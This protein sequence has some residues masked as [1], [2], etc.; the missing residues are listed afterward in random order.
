MQASTITNGLWAAGVFNHQHDAFI[1]A[2]TARAQAVAAHMPLQCACTILW[3]LGRLRYRDDAATDALAGAV[4]RAVRK[5]QPQLAP[6]WEDGRTAP[7]R[8]APPAPQPL[9]ELRP[10]TSLQPPAVDANSDALVLSPSPQLQ[11]AP[12]PVVPPLARPAR[13]PAQAAATPLPRGAPPVAAVGRSLSKALHA[14]ASLGC[15]DSAAAQRM[16]RAVLAFSNAHL[17]SLTAQSVVNVTWAATVA[18]LH[19]ERAAVS[20]LLLS[21]LLRGDELNA[22]EL[23]Q[24]AQVDFAL[25]LEAPWYAGNE[26]LVEGSHSELLTALYWLGATRCALGARV[27]G[28]ARNLL[29]PSWRASAWRCKEPSCLCCAARC[30]PGH[31]QLCRRQHMERVPT[32]RSPQHILSETASDSTSDAGPTHLV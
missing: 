17:P 31:R 13:P 18:G 12:A 3:A 30:S 6:M 5:L 24:L 21:A 8:S 11:L 27:H 23:A 4:V 9:T 32:F 25:R 1:A 16:T 10:R 29:E 28:A 26:W 19:T 22:L 15:F 14:V 7:P 2:S 20:E